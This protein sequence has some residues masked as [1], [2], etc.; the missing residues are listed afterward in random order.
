VVDDDQPVTGANVTALVARPDTGEYGSPVTLLDNG[1][2]PDTEADDGV[3]TATYTPLGNPP[4]NGQYHVYG[5]II[6][7]GGSFKRQV[8]TSF[9]V[10]EPEAEFSTTSLDLQDNGVDDNSN[11]LFDR[12]VVSAK[13][14][15]ATAGTYSLAAVMQLDAETSIVGRSRQVLSTG[16]GVTI[17]AQF[18]AL[19]FLQA[20]VW[21]AYTIDRLELVYFDETPG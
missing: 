4:P 1:Q 13:V 5:E 20:D 7:A 15:V 12:V 10:Y 8:G 19:E 17:E 16:S 14:D 2:A 11:S 9:E 18:Y 6:G 3:Y 21:G